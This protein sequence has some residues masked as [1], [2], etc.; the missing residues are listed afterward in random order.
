MSENAAKIL[1]REQLQRC[2][3]KM[4]SPHNSFPHRQWRD[5]D[6]HDQAQRDRIADLEAV[7]SEAYQF[8]GTVG[9]P[10][11]V[12]D[13]LSDAVQGNPLRHETILPVSVDECAEVQR[14]TESR[15][16]ISALFP[17]DAPHKHPE[18]GVSL[19]DDVRDLI[20]ENAELR[21]RIRKARQA[22]STAPWRPES[23]NAAINPPTQEA[24][25]ELPG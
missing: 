13:N 12:L 10:V 16:A 25:A 11:R 18:T 21:N 23:S 14:L 6:A 24:P 7:C 20:A 22:L 15:D 1:S 17:D 19:L 2:G 5:L 4:L 3:E 9:A 8:A